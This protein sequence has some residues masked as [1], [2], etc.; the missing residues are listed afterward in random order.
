MLPASWCCRR[1]SNARLGSTDSFANMRGWGKR[2]VWLL[3]ITRVFQPY[4]G[5]GSAR[6][7]GRST[8]S[9]AWPAA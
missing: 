5:P 3:T 4:L 7:S 6:S 8:S 9:V 2:V 1:P